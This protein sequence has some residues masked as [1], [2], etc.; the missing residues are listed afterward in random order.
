MSLMRASTPERTRIF[1]S[2]SHQDR[3]Y[4]DELLTHLSYYEK[5]GNIAFWGDT[6]I[7]PGS[8]WHREVERFI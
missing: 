8:D 3:K 7:K 2:Y 5:Q 1:I 4:L 6:K